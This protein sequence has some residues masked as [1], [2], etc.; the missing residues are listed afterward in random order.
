MKKL[1]L[2]LCL[3]AVLAFGQDPVWQVNY[4]K[5]MQYMSQG[6]YENAITYLKM[7]VAD[8]P[9]SEI[10]DRDTGPIEYLPYLQLGIAYY[11]I[12]KTQLATEFLDLESSLSAVQ[13][14]KT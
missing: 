12:R 13:K 11:K 5:A 3:F 1:S 10:V 9:I 2:L 7:A 4:G 8:K 6:N 14:S